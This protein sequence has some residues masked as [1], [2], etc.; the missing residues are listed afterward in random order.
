MIEKKST[1]W[2]VR[3]AALI[4][5]MFAMLFCGIAY[6]PGIAGLEMTTLMIPVIIGAIILGA[7]SG[8]ILGAV[9]GFISFMDCLGISGHIS[10]FGTTLFGIN[11]W[12]TLITCMVPRIL[13]GWLTGLIFEALYKKD[14]TKAHVLS[15]STA[16]IIGPL[17]NTVFFMLFVMVLFGSTSYIAEMRAGKGLLSFIVWFVGLNGLVE[18]ILSFFVGGAI[19]KALFKFARKS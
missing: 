9:F 6:I 7:K 4:A 2:L 3:M 18:I 5:I 12:L 16:S 11:P 8:A 15:F 1:K 19:S 17:L 14:K 10:L 13:M